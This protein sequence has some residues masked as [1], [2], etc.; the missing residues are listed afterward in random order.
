[1]ADEIDNPLAFPIYSPD[2]GTASGMTL[3]DYAALQALPAIIA[4]DGAQCLSSKKRQ[5]E[6]V[7]IAYEYGDLVIEYRTKVSP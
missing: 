4:A 5:A 1:M 3:R 7:A 2:C 6:H